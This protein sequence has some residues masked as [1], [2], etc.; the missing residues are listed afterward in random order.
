M[1]LNNVKDTNEFFK[2]VES[3]KGTVEL[4]TSEGDR[5]NLKSQ[6]T[7]YV[8]LAG[9]FSNVNIPELEIVCHEAEDVKKMF[10]Y[11]MGGSTNG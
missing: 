9:L 2:V 10:D 1:K 3:C 6:L 8:A 11:M 5:L 7:K 4:I